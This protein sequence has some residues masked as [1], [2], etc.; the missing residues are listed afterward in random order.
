MS[1]IRPD[2]RVRAH[3]LKK[4]DCVLVLNDRGERTPEKIASIDHDDCTL[5]VVYESGR[6]SV[7]GQNDHVYLKLID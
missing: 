7:F 1:Y 3:K 6:K 2:R 5:D 4:G